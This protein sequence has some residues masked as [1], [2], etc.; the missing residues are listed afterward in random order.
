[1]THR[2]FKEIGNHLVSGWGVDD[3]GEL[4]KKIMAM[5]IDLKMCCLLA[6]IVDELRDIAQG[7]STV[8][9]RLYASQESSKKQLP[10]EDHPIAD[11]MLRWMRGS[12][13]DKPIAEMDRSKLGI[14]AIKAL[15]RSGVK[16]RSQITRE[17][18]E[19][20]KNCGETT[21]AELLEWAAS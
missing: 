21:I 2:K 3:G 13:G 5:P 15:I 11:G 20:V 18:F 1:M 10:I 12:V 17:A 16:F 9:Y 7:V 4:D 19:E 14:R 8:R 6:V